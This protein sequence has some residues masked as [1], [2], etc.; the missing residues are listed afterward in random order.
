MLKSLSVENRMESGLEAWF[1]SM[2]EREE[3]LSARVA[4]SSLGPNPFNCVSSKFS[5]LTHQRNCKIW[6]RRSKER[7]ECVLLH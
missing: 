1:V 6:L 3:R 5:S 4:S 7:R 2:S